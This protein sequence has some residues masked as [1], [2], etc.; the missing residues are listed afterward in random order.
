M[1]QKLKEASV[2]NIDWFLRHSAAN[3]NCSTVRGILFEEY[4]VDHQSQGS[5]VSY[6]C[7]SHSMDKR[8]KGS[9]IQYWHGRTFYTTDTLL[10]CFSCLINASHLLMHSCLTIPL[11]HQ[12][13][14]SH[15]CRSGT[16]DIQCWRGQTLQQLKWDRHRAQQW[17]LVAKEVQSWGS[18]FLPPAQRIV[19]GHCQCWPWQ[20]RHDNNPE[21]IWGE[22]CHD[23]AWAKPV[24]HFCDASTYER[25][26]GLSLHIL[27]IQELCL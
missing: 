21:G 24:M 16:C 23:L 26:N 15:R 9:Y 25:W 22:S 14:F 2:H 13:V 3:Q 27:A 11:M 12:K 17:S 10:H 6:E 5:D 1:Y 4:V 18:R 20:A 8:V 19:P 7:K